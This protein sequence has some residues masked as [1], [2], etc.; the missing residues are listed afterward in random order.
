MQERTE[1]QPR[2]ASRQ[3]LP[4]WHEVVQQALD[5]ALPGEPDLE[6]VLERIERAAR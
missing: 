1:P 2:Q 4:G 5:G 6:T 3:P